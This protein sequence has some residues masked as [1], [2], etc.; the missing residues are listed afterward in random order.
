[1][2]PFSMGLIGFA[3]AGGIAAMAGDETPVFRAARP[4]WPEGLEK[5]MNLL[6]GFRAVIE[7]PAGS[8]T[9]LTLTGCSIYRVFVNGRFAGHGPARGPHGWF[10]VDE[11]DLT[12]LLAPGPSVVAV[13]VSAFNVNTYYVPHQPPFLQAEVAADGRVLAATGVEGGFVATVLDTR[14]RKVERYSHQRA[15]SE[16][17]RLR[18][19][20]DAWRLDPAAA[21][22]PAA[23]AVL[24]PV[25]LLPRRVPYPAYAVIRP[26]RHV[27]SGTLAPADETDATRWLETMK[28][29]HT[30]GGFTREEFQ[31]LPMADLLRHAPARL[32]PV[33]RTLGADARFRLADKTFH[34]LDFG[35]EL[36]GFIGLRVR[37]AGPCRLLVGFDEI[38]NR[39]VVDCTRMDC[40]NVLGFELAPGTYDLES[41]EPYSL[42]YLELTVMEG[43]CEVENVCLREYA[44]DD[45]RHA[46]FTCSDGRLNTLYA[47]ARQTFRQNALDI[48]MDCPSRE[49][50]GWLCDSFFTARVAADLNGHTLIEKVFLENYLLPERF[51]NLPEGMLPMCYPA[52]HGVNSFIPNWAMWFVLQLEEYG[53]RS[54]DRAMIDG[55]RPRVEKLF[56]Y[57][58]RFRNA[59]GLLEKL[60]SW[61][62]VEWSRCQ[63]FV[64]DVNYPTNMLWAGALEA[65]GRMYHRRD[66]LE[67]AG[68]IRE[69]V[70]RQSFNGEF[71]VDNAVR[72]DGELRVTGNRTETCQYY[73]FYFGVATPETHER[74]L[75]LLIDHFG[76]RRR[77]AFEWPDI[78]RSNQ[79]VGNMLRLEILSRL[80][81]VRQML[82][83]LLRYNLYMAERTGTL[84]EN[85]DTVASCN[86]GFASHAA[87]VLIR[88][89]LGVFACDPVGRRVHVR[90]PDLPLEH[91][92]GR[93]PTVHGVVELSWQKTRD[94][95]E[96]RLR[97]PEGYAA[98]VEN[99]SGLEAVA[100]K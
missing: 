66:W 7:A 62:F 35:T 97:M 93:V 43:A 76:P 73:A 6:V 96:Y 48:F 57:F 29:N 5:E 53:R 9:V 33:D 47:A 1:M 44:N 15:F 61:V 85:N 10:R 51:A 21:P 89:V 32:E 12:G 64:Q 3:L 45:L 41:I 84:W 100:V 67:E 26:V 38:L 92:S 94:R 83:D 46:S 27:S 22:E 95:I 71:F 40:S 39:G 90:L 37:A 56:D 31:A 99:L 79:L 30:R 8:R 87:H 14:V 88:D 63:D 78:H 81:R 69:V 58:W 75:T 55:L 19:G 11:L 72:V 65:A 77:A 23:C 74:L 28:W 52:D 59:D 86:H 60:E 82:D 98:E 13:E 4:V 36:T 91:C 2:S 20:W 49:R 25:R 24:E 18:P 16:S 80:G 70:R 50:A 34:V 42:R 68:R 54:G 17:Y